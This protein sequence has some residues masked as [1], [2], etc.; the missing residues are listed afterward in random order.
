MDQI[1]TFPKKSQIDQGIQELTKSPFK[2]FQGMWS[3]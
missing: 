3:A 2:K 1:K